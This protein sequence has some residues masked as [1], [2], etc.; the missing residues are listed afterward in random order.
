MSK[1]KIYNNGQWVDPT[2]I[3]VYQNGSW[4][5]LTRV[6]YR[7]NNAWEEVWPL[8][9]PAPPF[10]GDIFPDYVVIKIELDNPQYWSDLNF[11]FQLINPN[12]FA[13]PEYRGGQQIRIFDQSTGDYSETFLF[14]SNPR[15]VFAPEKYLGDRV[16]RQEK[17]SV[18]RVESRVLYTDNKYSFRYIAGVDQISQIPE[19]TNNPKYNNIFLDLKSFREDFVDPEIFNFDSNLGIGEIL[20]FGLFLAWD[21]GFQNTNENI[22]ITYEFYKGG[23]PQLDQ[24]NA[25]VNVV[26]FDQLEVFTDTIQTTAIDEPYS[27]AYA[28]PFNFLD[29]YF[30]IDFSVDSNF[31]SFGQYQEKQY[32]YTQGIKIATTS[33]TTAG[34][35][36]YPIW[37][38][39]QPRVSPTTYLDAPL[40]YIK[41]NQLEDTEYFRNSFPTEIAGT[42]PGM[43]T[44]EETIATGGRFSNGFYPL[45][46]GGTTATTNLWWM[47]GRPFNSFIP[48][49]NSTNGNY[50][51]LIFDRW[52][53]KFD[54][55]DVTE[56]KLKM[57]AFTESGGQVNNAG[58]S[59]I[60][61]QVDEVD[62]LDKAGDTDNIVWDTV[63][64][65]GTVSKTV[66]PGSWPTGFAIGDPPVATPVLEVTINLDNGN[67]TVTQL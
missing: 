28:L 67:A 24:Q 45:V 33:A 38:I 29:S 41:N 13:L 27:S 26:N 3:S 10:T 49:I 48:D 39:D 57:F 37:F 1:L 63:S 19:L 6:N 22:N 65:V 40:F 46:S 5:S 47:T 16:G 61:V 44:P 43:D 15:P 14:V 56:V 11:E 8:E 21:Q 50:Q 4:N 66:N 35:S 51:F 62:I 55:P 32:N 54:N 12:P 9:E 52:Q 23:Q 36:L 31:L 18:Q 34:G 59:D 42:G 58:P 64:T 20:R 60:T 30:D 2:N 17:K 53:Y 25:D 7:K